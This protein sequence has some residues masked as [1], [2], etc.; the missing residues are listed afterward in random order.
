[1]GAS[2]STTNSSQ[3]A[4]DE[5]KGLLGVYGVQELLRT[6]KLMKKAPPSWGTK[7]EDL[8]AVKS[9]ATAAAEPTALLEV[10]RAKEEAY[11]TLPS[12]PPVAASPNAL[13]DELHDTPSHAQECLAACLPRR[14]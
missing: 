8:W 3:T 11:S 2:G 5:Q 13:T 9:S 7:N 1:M 10:Q 4:P 14:L 12:A 6:E